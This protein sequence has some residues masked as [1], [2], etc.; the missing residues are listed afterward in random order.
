M[1]VV[2]GEWI[3]ERGGGGVGDASLM[4]PRSSYERVRIGGLGAVNGRYE[5]GNGPGA[6]VYTRGVE[7]SLCGE[8]R[9]RPG[10]LRP[11]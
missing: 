9:G 7:A 10:R 1:V 6:P 8:D 2:S 4:H 5:C 11:C 3:K